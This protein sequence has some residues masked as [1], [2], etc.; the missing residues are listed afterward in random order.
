MLIHTIPIFVVLSLLLVIAAALGAPPTTPSPVLRYLASFALGAL[1]AALIFAYYQNT[2]HRRQTK[3]P[4]SEHVHV[5][6]PPK[7]SY[8]DPERVARRERVRLEMLAAPERVV[9]ADARRAAVDL[10]PRRSRHMTW[11]HALP[12]RLKDPP[13][14]FGPCNCGGA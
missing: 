12:D 3:I 14:P 1:D 11:C 6:L 13:V 9:E 10:T 4:S 8:N 7:G 5:E 2:E